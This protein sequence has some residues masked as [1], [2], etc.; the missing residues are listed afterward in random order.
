[1]GPKELVKKWVEIFNRAD[2]NKLSEL[3]H[4]DAVNHQVANE[5]VIG[6]EAIKIM[7]AEE[8]STADMTCIPHQAWNDN[9]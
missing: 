7:F 4:K 2:S 6:K 8:V 9:F 3:Y 5:P 1:M